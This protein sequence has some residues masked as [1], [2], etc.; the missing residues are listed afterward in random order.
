MA[1]KST[2]A[3]L[4]KGDTVMVI[5][6]G[7]HKKRAIK[8]KTGK[9][10]RFEGTN[11]DRVVVEGLNFITKFKKPTGPNSPGGRLVVEGGMHISNVLFYVEKL[12][13]PVRLKHKI[14]EDGK[15]VR[16]YIDPTSKSFV[17]IE[18]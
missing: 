14:L 3:G 7:N 12:K 17:Q 18:G 10:V 8:G 15:K 4:R 16:G 6:G 11:G 13:K 9:I 2:R 1:G 5:A